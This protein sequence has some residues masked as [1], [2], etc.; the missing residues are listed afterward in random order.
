LRVAVIDSTSLIAL[1]HLNLARQLSLFFDIVYI[2][3]SVQGEVNRKYRFRRR[4]QKLYR[5]SVFR[6]CLTADTIRVKLLTINIDEG[7][8]EALVQAQERSATFFIADEKKARDFGERQGLKP[9]GTVNLLARLHLQGQ[10]N[11]LTVLVR[12]LRIEIGF[13]VTDAIVDEAIR[14]ASEPI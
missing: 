2:P 3:R 14:R 11:E 5:T 13:R 9:V 10:A 7:E 4:V 12:K 8:A 1:V 6:K